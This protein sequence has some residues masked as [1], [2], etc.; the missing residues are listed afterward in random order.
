MRTPY[1]SFAP[2]F[3]NLGNT[4]TPRQMAPEVIR[5]DPYNCQVDVFA[6]SI[7]A[8]EL[9]MLR[10]P[11]GAD[12]SGEFVK[13]CVAIYCDRPSPIPRKWPHALRNLIQEGWAQN[14]QARP[15]SLA[16]RVK[17]EGILAH[18]EKLWQKHQEQLK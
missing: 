7:V 4:G 5:R 17:L 3:I 9:L 14:G 13:E 11:Y 1:G 16:M 8:W 6:T 15:S 18:E 2:H 10:K 12:M